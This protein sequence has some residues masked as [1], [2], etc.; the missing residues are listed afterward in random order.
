MYHQ[1]E[2][3]YIGFTTC[4]SW[5]WMVIA[6]CAVLYSI[7]YRVAHNLVLK[8]VRAKQQKGKQTNKYCDTRTHSTKR[9]SF[10]HLSEFASATLAPLSWFS[11]VL[12]L[13]FDIVV[14]KLLSPLNWLPLNRLGQTLVRYQ[15]L[16]RAKR[17]LRITK[18]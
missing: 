5:S 11:S 7:I 15:T 16:S 4:C 8:S 10:S 13:R 9:R 1:F 18:H 6:R 17:I 2:S 14:S 12:L 3:N